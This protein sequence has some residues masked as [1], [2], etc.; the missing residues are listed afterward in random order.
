MQKIIASLALGMLLT[1]CEAKLVQEIPDAPEGCVVSGTS[2]CL[3]GQCTEAVESCE[4]LEISSF[5]GCSATCEPIVECTA[6]EPEETETEPEAETEEGSGDT[7]EATEPAEDEAAAKEVAKETAL[8]QV[9]PDELIKNEMPMVIDAETSELPAKRSYYI[10][11]GARHELTEFDAE[12]LT[13][14]CEIPET[15]VH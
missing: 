5:A 8:L 11:E 3:D 12:W 9:C 1:G 4:V 10:L 2:C 15:T 13:D 6:V 7:T 14:N